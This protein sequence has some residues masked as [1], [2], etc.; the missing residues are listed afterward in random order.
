LTTKFYIR[1]PV[2]PPRASAE[3]KTTTLHQHPIRN[4]GSTSTK[5]STR[6]G[7][8][9]TRSI[10]INEINQRRRN[11]GE[12]PHLHPLQVQVD[13]AEK[14]E[15]RNNQLLNCLPFVFITCT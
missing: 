4:A 11:V 10:V 14:S 13:E 9:M 6:R 7:V 1:T 15:E 2:I 8:R 12:I 3:T 5:I